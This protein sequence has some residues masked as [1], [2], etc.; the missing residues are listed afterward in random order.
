MKQP[1]IQNQS[2]ALIARPAR[3]VLLII[4]ILLIAANLRAPVTG[5]SPLLEAIRDSFGLNSIEAGLLITLPLLAFA[6]VSPFAALLAKAYGLERSLFAALIL[7]GTGIIVRSSGGAV[8]SLYLGTCIIGGGIAIGNVLLPSLL[9]RDF[10]H[11]ITKLTAVYALTMGGSAALVSAVAI[12]LAHAFAWPH[13]LEILVLLPFISAIVWLPQLRDRSAPAQGTATQLH[14]GPVWRSPLAWQV[15][16]F[17]G[18][19][20]FVY[21][22]AAAWLPTILMDAGYS[23]AKAGNLHGL[24]QLA[25]A[26]PGLILVPLVGRMKDQRIIAFGMVL[27]AMIGFLGLMAAPAWATLWTVLLGLGMGAVLI[28]GLAFVSLRASNPH[29]AAALSGMAQCVGYLLAATGPMLAGVIHDLAGNWN[30]ALG[31]CAALC[32]PMAVLGLYA[33]RAIHIGAEG[34]VGNF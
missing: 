34:H 21:Y 31:I 19:N 29:Q 26:V 14:A 24:L 27:L 6:I 25:T 8:W 4:G 7:I 5:V 32:L 22:I 30:V 1:S 17:L 33:G 11:Q 10:P 9:K 3:P 23:A 2:A 16:L 13:A 18:L 15:T 20:S 28:L 12:P